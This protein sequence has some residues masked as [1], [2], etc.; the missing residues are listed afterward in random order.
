VRKAG[1]TLVEVLMAV[2]ITGIILSAVYTCFVGTVAARQYSE[3]LRESGRTGQAILGLMKRDFEGMFVFSSDNIPLEGRSDSIGSSDA[4]TLN[5]VTTSDSRRAVNGIG[6][7][8]NEV[9]Y[10]LSLNEERDGLLN[11]YRREDQYV[12][13]SPFAGGVLELLDDSIKSLKLEYFKEGGWYLQWQ[14]GELPEAI[15]ITLVLRKESGE[16]MGGEPVTRDY[17]YTAVALVPAGC[18]W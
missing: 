16:M 4:N 18:S 17:A 14:E 5:F 1:F 6:S 8:Y 15:K 7:D 2:L 3:Q 9:G 11:L 12:D 13:E 10:I